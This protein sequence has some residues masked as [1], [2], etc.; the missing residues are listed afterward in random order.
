MLLREFFD[1]LF[2]GFER[3]ASGAFSVLR[4]SDIAPSDRFAAPITP[5][6]TSP[7]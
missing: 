1:R 3:R 2:P 4:D 7:I 6:R 5:A